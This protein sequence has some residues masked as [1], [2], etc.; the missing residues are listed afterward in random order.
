VIRQKKPAPFDA[1]EW[2]DKP[3]KLSFLEENLEN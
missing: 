1:D 2:K 3:N